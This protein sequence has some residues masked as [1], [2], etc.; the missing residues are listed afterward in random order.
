L[1][2]TLDA[3]VLL[4]A[5]NEDAPE[6]EPA[7]R[8]VE[9]LGGGPEILYL[10]WPTIMA[11][12]RIATHPAILPTP[13]SAADAIET[14]ADLIGQPHVRTPGEAEGFWILYLDTEGARSRAND[15]PDAHLATLMRQHGVSV[16][17]T[18]DR[19]FRRFPGIEVRDPLEDR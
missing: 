18:R 17:H 4:Y 2:Q 15:V 16:I 12:L 19:G 10:F 6:H 13:L 7:L 11:F 1:S 14:V 9:H 8:L 5:V 3:N